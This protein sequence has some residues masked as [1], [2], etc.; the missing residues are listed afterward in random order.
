MV[1]SFLTFLS[2]PPLFSFQCFSFSFFF[3]PNFELLKKVEI[4]APKK[5][6]LVEITPQKKKKKK[7]HKFQNFPQEK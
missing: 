7:N 1:R 3:S 5:E 4:F 2:I 6:I